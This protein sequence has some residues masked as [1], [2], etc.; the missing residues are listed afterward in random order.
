MSL[1]VSNVP[2]WAVWAGHTAALVALPSSLWRIGLALGHP[3]GY[4]QQ[5]LHDLV[6]TDQWGPVYLVA[7]S[8]LAEIA[9]IL[10]LALIHPWGEVVPRWVPRLGGTT[11]PTKAVLIPAWTA[12]AI[13]TLLWTQLLFWWTIPHPGMTEQGRLLVGLLYM[14]LIAWAPLMAATTIAYQRRRRT[15]TT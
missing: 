2:R 4:T 10:T 8:V 3:L 5:G 15:Q 11:I 12:V 14:P 1:T 7:L 6:G 9:A 13:H